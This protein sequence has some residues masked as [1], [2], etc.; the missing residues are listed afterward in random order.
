MLSVHNRAARA[1]LLGPKFPFSFSFSDPVRL[2]DKS[3]DCV[4]D[5]QFQTPARHRQTPLEITDPDKGTVEDIERMRAQGAQKKRK[6]RPGGF[7]RFTMAEDL[8]QPTKPERLAYSMREAAKMLDVSAGLL[9]LEVQ[10]GRLR[11]IRIGKRMVLP[12]AE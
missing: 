5:I 2:A 6:R 7:R 11:V 1:Q 12:R 10:R 8:T 3:F 9:L 4:V